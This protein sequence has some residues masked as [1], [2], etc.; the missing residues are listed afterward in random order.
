MR[1][2]ISTIAALAG[3]FC[4]IAAIASLLVFMVQAFRGHKTKAWVLSLVCGIALFWCSI[5]AA[6]FSDSSAEKTAATDNRTATAIETEPT[7]QIAVAATAPVETDTE[8][9]TET[10]L[11]TQEVP[12]KVDE[13]ENHRLAVYEAYD[14]DGTY[15]G[16][17]VSIEYYTGNFINTP[18][19]L[20][21]DL[22]AS[23]LDSGCVYANIYYP[24]NTCIRAAAKEATLMINGRSTS[25]MMRF[26]PERR[27]TS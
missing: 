21:H 10:P 2:L 7:A 18:H 27:I 1:W 15:I 17:R 13:D 25:P 16:Q 3:L 24:D 12:I 14:T 20:L 5:I 9:P 26:I 6:L 11:I 19:S 22:I 4:A 23:I 8:T